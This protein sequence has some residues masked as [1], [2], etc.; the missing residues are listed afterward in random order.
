M[1]GRKDKPKDGDKK[2]GKKVRVD[3]RR[4]RAQPARDNSWT[5]QYREHG[6][7]HTEP[8]TRESLNPKGDLSRKR[9]IIEDADLSHLDLREGKVLAMRGLIAEVDDGDQ[10]WPCTVRRILRTRQIDERHPVAV[11][12][13]VRFVPNA[14]EPGV[15]RSGMIYDVYERTSQL[16]R[17]YANRVHIIAANVDRVLI[18][19][20]VRQPPL[21]PHLIDRYVVAAH[22]GQIEPIICINKLDLANGKDIDSVAKMYEV[23]GYAVVL[24]SAE[25]GAGLKE[26]RRHM[27]DHD[28]VIV[29]QSG[30]G[31]SSLLN[32]LEPG[33]KLA[34]GE[35][36]EATTKGRHT[37]TT[38]CLLKLQS[39]GYVIDT[40]GIRSYDLAVIPKNEYELHF[41][42][43]VDYVPQCKF[44]DCTHTHE[45]ACAVKAAVDSGHIDPRRYQSYVRMFNE[46]EYRSVEQ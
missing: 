5:R 38:A 34:T 17:R 36:S 45:D 40:P 44:P 14:A 7:K 46:E 35:V 3:F 12:D 26:L 18:V 1:A 4:N 37:T 41:V 20:S 27:A 15:Q 43:F 22:A 9:T 23:I 33:L 16:V 29:G 11:G 24:T 32:A 42:E 31:K 21:K 13:R 10:V 2:K 39:G 28:T 19:S 30:V 8:V 25:T 6:F